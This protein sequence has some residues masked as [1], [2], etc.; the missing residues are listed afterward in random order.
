M[1]SASTAET[2]T[3]GLTQVVSAGLT[4]LSVGQPDPRLLPTSLVA[5]H[6][7]AALAAYGPAV[8][9]YGANAGPWPAREALA[10]WS[11]SVESGGWG[12]AEVLVTAGATHALDLLCTHLGR[13]GD[14]VL[15]QRAS[16]NLALDLFRYRGLL[17]WP[18]G[19]DLRIPDTSD[20]TE[21]VRSVKN[22]GR[23]IAFAYFIP[24][25]HNPTGYSWTRSE[26]LRIL[27]T[28]ESLGI[29]IIEDDPYRELFFADRQADSLAALSNGATVLGIRTLSKILAP[30]LRLGWII[31]ERSVIDRLAAAPLFASGGGIAHIAALAATSLISS[32]AFEP[33]LAELRSQYRQRRDALLQQLTR[34]RHIGADWYQPDGGFFVWIGLPRGVRANAVEQMAATMGAPILNGLR[35]CA[36]FDDTQYVRAS[37]SMY[38]PVEIAVAGNSLASAIEEAAQAATD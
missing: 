26:R 29:M 34:V 7:N 11:S 10:I 12:A 17:P 28:C 30:G 25:F 4:D 19:S 9:S 14:C 3:A 27:H 13:N 18:V 1:R 35:C 23:G 36:L 31:A 5:H 32:T 15:V 8:L 21:A 20:L 2:G 22:S 38:S 16:Y 37:F 24:T 33:H 6:M